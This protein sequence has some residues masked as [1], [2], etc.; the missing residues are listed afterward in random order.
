[1]THR[2]LPFALLQL[3][4][5]VVFF[6]DVSFVLCGCGWVYVLASRVPNLLSVGTSIN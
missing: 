1:M 4:Y 2:L 3:I 6:S 5:L